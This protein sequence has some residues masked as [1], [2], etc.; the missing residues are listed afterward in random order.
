MKITVNGEAKQY[1]QAVV[2]VADLLVLEQV[3][4]PEMVSVQQNGDFVATEQFETT[5]IHDGD[6]IDFLF[7]MGGGSIPDFSNI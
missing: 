7:F 3:A 2:T 4:S 5:L 6:E 1:E